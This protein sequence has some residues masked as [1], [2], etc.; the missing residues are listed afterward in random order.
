MLGEYIP[1]KDWT[2]DERRMHWFIPKLA[3]A[4]LIVL[5]GCALLIALIVH[6]AC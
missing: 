3:G 2:D 5:A 1:K 4:I 6:L